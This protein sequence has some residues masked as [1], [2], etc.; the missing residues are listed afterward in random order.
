[1]Y[2]TY[3]MY[4]RYWRNWVCR[5]RGSKLSL[6]WNDVCNLQNI[7]NPKNLC[8]GMQYLVVWRFNGAAWKNLVAGAVHW[9]TRRR[10]RV[11]DWGWGGWAERLIR[12]GQKP[13]SEPNIRSHQHV[14]FAKVAPNSQ[15]WLVSYT[16]RILTNGPRSQRTRDKDQRTRAAGDEESRGPMD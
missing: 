13:Q 9:Q 3:I 16:S 2:I 12:K 7:Y 15:I 5:K 6:K 4:L 11:A 8:E 10:F 14:C 1:M